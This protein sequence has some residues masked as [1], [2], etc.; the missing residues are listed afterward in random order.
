KMG[1]DSLPRGKIVQN[2]R[3]TKESAMYMNDMPMDDQ[4]MLF[5]YMGSKPQGMTEEIILKMAE[6]HIERFSSMIQMGGPMIRLGE[7]RVYLRLW[8]DVKQNP[9]WEKLNPYQKNEVI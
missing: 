5:P 1:A 6:E 4:M 2:L 3:T 8:T 7:C 9:S